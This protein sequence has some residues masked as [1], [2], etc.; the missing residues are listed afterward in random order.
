[1]K[2]NIKATGI[3]LTTAIRS[4]LET[5]LEPLKKLLG[6]KEEG[7]IIQTELGK[8]TKH[9][10]HGEVFRAEINLSFAGK[11]LRA[12]ATANDLYAAID[13]VK[14]ELVQETK[15]GRSKA[16]SRVKRGARAAKKLLTGN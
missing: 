3:E 7:A 13:E 9:H 6:T 16:Q 11:Q 8:E 1:M 14:D 12:V 10:K 5:K 2:I 15:S 4:Y